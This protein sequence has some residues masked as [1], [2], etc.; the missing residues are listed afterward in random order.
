MYSIQYNSV[1]ATH[2]QGEFAHLIYKAMRSRLDVVDTQP[3]LTGIGRGF[4]VFSPLNTEV[5]VSPYPLVNDLDAERLQRRGFTPEEFSAG[6]HGLG[7]KII[8][9]NDFQ[10]WITVVR[11]LQGNENARILRS[12]Q[13]PPEYVP[14]QITSMDRKALRLIE[15]LSFYPVALQEEFGD[16][17][18]FVDVLTQTVAKPDF[19]G[20]DMQGRIEWDYNGRYLYHVNPG[21]GLSEFMKATKSIM[22]GNILRGSNSTLLA[23]AD[24]SEFDRVE[25]SKLVLQRVKHYKED[26]D[27]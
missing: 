22:D 13:T 6:G 21:F 14:C 23:A 20:I 5:H 2:E 15:E 1:M 9:S 24:F 19:R 8:G 7:Y 12:S 11:D 3:T 17:R 26:S 16:F 4:V 25:L 10:Y 18:T 27:R